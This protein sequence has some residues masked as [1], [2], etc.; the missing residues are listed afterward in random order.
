MSV[1]YH[2]AKTVLS[3][4]LLAGALTIDNDV[5]ASQLC[6]I[7]K[8]RINS[9]LEQEILINRLFQC[10]VSGNP[11]AQLNLGRM[12]VKLQPDIDTITESSG[13]KWYLKAAKQG[14][15]QAQFELALLYLEGNVVAENRSLALNWL[16]RAAR[17]GHPQA[18][19]VI[20]HILNDDFAVGC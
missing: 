18:Q 17:Q 4:G 1:R 20:D 19:F 15:R 16:D 9:S 12:L 13:V 10:A 8:S 14:L 11:L 3:C 5:L 2:L 7:P 6:T